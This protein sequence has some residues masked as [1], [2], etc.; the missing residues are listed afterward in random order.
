M[1]VAG[2]LLGEEDSRGIEF[3]LQVRLMAEGQFL[4]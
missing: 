3:H 4:H 2:W 1:E